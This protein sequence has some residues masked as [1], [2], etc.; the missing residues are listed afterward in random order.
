MCL[1]LRLVVVHAVL[2]SQW[3]N[4][5]L[6]SHVTT[7]VVRD[8]NGALDLQPHSE[9]SVFGTVASGLFRAHLQPA[10]EAISC[11]SCMLMMTESFNVC[12]HCIVY[13]PV[14]WREP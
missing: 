11:Y 4:Q 1:Q 3:L 10:A 6:Q 2:P 12:G 14:M 5:I 9:T 13:N 7:D 8:A